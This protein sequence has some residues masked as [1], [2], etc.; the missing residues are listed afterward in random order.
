MGD[1]ESLRVVLTESSVVG[2]FADEL[3]SMK[4]TLFNHCPISYGPP[5]QVG[6]YFNYA[7]SDVLL[8]K[9]EGCPIVTNGQ[10]AARTS[11]SFWRLLHKT[12]QDASA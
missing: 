6:L 5:P 10:S 9:V 8:V 2:T 4:L 1:G 7:A 12:E 3:N 11:S